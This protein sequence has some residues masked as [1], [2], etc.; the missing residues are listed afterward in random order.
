MH[1]EETAQKWRYRYRQWMILF[2]TVEDALHLIF[3]HLTPLP[4][5]G[6]KCPG[7]SGTL[8]GY[9]C[10]GI[11]GTVLDL[12]ALTLVPEGS[13]TSLLFVPDYPDSNH[14]ATT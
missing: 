10:P 8:I 7:I 3:H 5:I 11:S 12:E 4:L 9:K 14:P 13:S 1:R 6:Y 2:T